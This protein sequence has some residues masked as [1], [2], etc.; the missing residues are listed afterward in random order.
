MLAMVDW[1]GMFIPT[2]S[3]LEM[4]L[5]AT[6]MYFVVLGLMRLVAKRQM[7][8]IGATDIL[9]VVLVAEIAGPAFVA[10]SKSVGEAAVLV[11]TVLFWSFVLEWLTYRFPWA[12]R[13][14]QPRP[15]LLVRD[16]K[17]LHKNLRKELITREELMAQLRENG[18]RDISDVKEACME[19]DGMI[20][21]VAGKAA[22]KP[23]KK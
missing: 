21:V 11:M 6:L 1:S 5:R 4:F 8:G 20:S 9:V 12:E 18:L 16:G 17:I 7:G 10:D 19:A 22:A 14:V 13:I 2:H 23:T 15:L 3:A